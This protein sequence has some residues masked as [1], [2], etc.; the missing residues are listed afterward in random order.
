M[1]QKATVR[2]NPKTAARR[3]LIAA[4]A[5]TGKTQDQIA[6]ELDVARCTVNRDL[7]EPET[8]DYI[9]RLLEPRD[10]KL[11]ALVDKSFEAIDAGLTANRDDAA[12]HGARMR[13]VERTTKLL[14]LRAG[15]SDGDSNG[16]PL[17]FS[18]ELVELLALYAKFQAPEA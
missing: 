9:R 11:E 4:K 13:A 6:A 2:E 17:R 7:A 5:I 8:R 12:D 3:K 18:G 16:K 14:E 10:P 1:R 15:R